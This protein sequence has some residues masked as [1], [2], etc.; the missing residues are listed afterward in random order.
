MRMIWTWHDGDP[1]WGSMEEN[2]TNSQ[3]ITHQLGW[4]YNYPAHDADDFVWCVLNEEPTD[5]SSYYTACSDCSSSDPNIL[6]MIE[7]HVPNFVP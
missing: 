4:I 1:S 6:D 3:V 2:Y 5:W 7:E